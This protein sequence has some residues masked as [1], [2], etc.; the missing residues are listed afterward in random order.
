MTVKTCIAP[1]LRPRG[2]TVVEILVVISVL[3]ILI[4]FAVPGIGR[5]TARAEMKAAAENVQYSIDNAR[6]LARMTES[7]VTLHAD[8]PDGATV[9][10]IRLSGPG[11][12]GAMGVQEYRLPDSI[13]LVPDH[14]SY[15]FD[16]RGLVLDPG[17]LGLVLQVN[18]AIVSELEIN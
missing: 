3:L 18:E 13:I 14:E 11:L 7:S 1:S 4:S 9:Q 15:T 5:A 17:R 10:H 2:I 16:G 6:K 8:P 12:S